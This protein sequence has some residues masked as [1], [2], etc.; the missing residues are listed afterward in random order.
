[1]FAKI[2]AGVLAAVAVTG[3]GVY[4]A[5]P[6][7]HCKSCC[8]LSRTE[9]APVTASVDEVPST[10]SPE[11]TCCIPIPQNESLGACTGAATLVS[12]GKA[13]PAHACCS[14]E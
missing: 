14:D 10:C 3:V 8:P 4:V 5:M 11:P 1:M 9:S 6:D 12:T 13:K 7:T 2:A